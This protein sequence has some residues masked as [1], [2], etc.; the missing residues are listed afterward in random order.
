MQKDPGKDSYWS[1]LDLP[2]PI[3]VGAAAQRAV[4]GQ[5]VSRVCSQSQ[6][7]AQQLHPLE[8]RG[9]S[10]NENSQKKKG[11]GCWADRTFPAVIS[12][13][14]RP[15]RVWLTAGA[16]SFLPFLFNF[17]NFQILEKTM[18]VPSTLV[19]FPIHWL[20]LFCIICTLSCSF[21]VHIYAFMNYLRISWDFPGS[22]VLKALWSQCRGP[23]FSPCSGNQIPHA[24]LRPGTAK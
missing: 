10:E 11:K 14:L 16:F 3:P 13:P 21:C 18:M 22:L 20:L 2:Q 23:W 9:G 5:V 8:P 6:D 17:A 1:S 15:G 4:I 24:Q 12:P 7:F 19:H